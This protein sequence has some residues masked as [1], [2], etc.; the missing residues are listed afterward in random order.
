[1][2]TKD[3]IMKSTMPFLSKLNKF[4]TDTITLQPTKL[5]NSLKPNRFKSVLKMFLRKNRFKI[6]Q[7]FTGTSSANK[8]S[9]EKTDH[10]KK[11]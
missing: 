11:V 1:M 3:K 7:M 4:S 9:Q 6:Y 2:A 10:Q 5:I 8:I